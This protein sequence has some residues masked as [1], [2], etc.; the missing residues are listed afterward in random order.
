MRI[1]IYL[2]E[3]K[4]A[5]S[6]TRAQWMVENG[7]VT[8]N[9]NK[10][11]KASFAVTENDVVGITEQPAYISMG[12]FKLEKAAGEMNIDFKGKTVLDIGSS[13]GGFTDYALKHGAIHVTCIDAGSNQ[14]HPDLRT[15][16]AIT[17][18]EN[19]DLRNFSPAQLPGG[20]AQIVLADLSFISLKKVIPDLKKFAQP[21]TVFLLLVKPQFEMEQRKNFKNGIVPTKYHTGILKD[22]EKS[23]VSAGFSFRGISPTTADGKNKNIEYFFHLLA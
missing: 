4:L 2:T 17:L 8:V 18:S 5:D 19:T 12:G 10:I 11:T 9:G 14:L 1:D 15:N 21:G 23:F 20:H 13:T 6:R 22:L 16:P 7:M 3:K